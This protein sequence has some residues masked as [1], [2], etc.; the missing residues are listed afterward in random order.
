MIYAELKKGEISQEKVFKN[1]SDITVITRHLSI[2]F[3]CDKVEYSSRV[4]FE[5][6]P[7][8]ND[9]TFMKNKKMILWHLSDKTVAPWFSRWSLMA[10]H[11]YFLK[12]SVA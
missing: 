2:C 12:Q 6:S 1:L 4:N 7:I 8:S 9:V 10:C 11:R 5:S 3:H